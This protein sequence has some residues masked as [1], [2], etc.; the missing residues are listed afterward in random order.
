MPEKPYAIVIEDD[1]KLSA[2]FQKAI[3]GAG[4]DVAVDLN[5]DKYPSLL[6]A[7]EPALVIL[8]LHLPYASGADILPIVRERYPNTVIAIVTADL[9]QAKSLPALADHVLVK[10]VSMARLLKIAEA[11]KETA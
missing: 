5:G 2:I 9:Y 8:D 7:A 11:A 6:D 1:P 3:Q 4:F 10:P